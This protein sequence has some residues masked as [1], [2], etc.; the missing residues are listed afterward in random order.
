MLE[1]IVGWKWWLALFGDEVSA[2]GA[3]PD[4]PKH[5]LSNWEGSR[6][7]PAAGEDP[8]PDRHPRSKA[9]SGAV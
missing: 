6:V 2:A 1:L 5:P 8:G 9:A 7:A 4:G 3:D